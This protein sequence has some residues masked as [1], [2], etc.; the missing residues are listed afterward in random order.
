MIFVHSLPFFAVLINLV[1]TRGR[2]ISSHCVYTMIL[3]SVYSIV[4]YFGAQYRGY[5]L[6]PFL[7]WENPF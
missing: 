7:K 4:N 6:Y 3:G 2:F 1:I 5:N